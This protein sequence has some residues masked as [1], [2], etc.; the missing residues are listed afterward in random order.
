MTG[1][2][3]TD[4]RHHAKQKGVFLY[5]VAEVLQISDPTF[6]RRL[7]HELSDKDKQEIFTIIDKLAAQH[8]ATV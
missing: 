2:F 8:T 6:T 7:R 1:R 4:I 5:E 3:N